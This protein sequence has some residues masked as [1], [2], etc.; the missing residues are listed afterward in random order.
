MIFSVFQYLKT[1]ADPVGHFRTLGVPRV[2]P[3]GSFRTGNDAAVFRIVRDV[4]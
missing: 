2:V 4:Q 3:E 1:L